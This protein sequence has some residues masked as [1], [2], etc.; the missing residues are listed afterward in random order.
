[1]MRATLSSILPEISPVVPAEAAAEADLVDRAFA[2][3]LYRHLPEDAERRELER[4]KRG[5]GGVTVR[6]LRRH[7]RR[8]EVVGTS[9]VLEAGTPYARCRGPGEAEIRLIAVDPE[10]QGT[11]LGEALMRASLEVALE[12]GADPRCRLGRYSTGEA[13]SAASCATVI[14]RCRS[15]AGAARRGSGRARP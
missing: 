13:V 15:R 12:W 11:G 14:G 9:S 3:C 1:M 5:S 4:A 2:A 10:V 8:T 7:G 6:V